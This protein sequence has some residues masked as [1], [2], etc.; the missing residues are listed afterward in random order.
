[1][2]AQET[3]FELEP[4]VADSAS[5]PG[6]PAVDDSPPLTPEQLGAITS[7]DS[8]VF[9]EA[10]AGTGKTRVL[11]ERYCD[12]VE[13]DGVGPEAILAFTFTERAAAELRTRIRRE[14]TARAAVARAR[15]DKQL[16]TQLRRAARETERAWVTTI[17][18][19]CRRLLGGHPVAA[20]IDPRFRVLDEGEA[21]R[22]RR[23]ARDQA[24]DDV[25]RD[26]GPET[27]ETI[28]AYRPW[29]FGEMAIAAHG[30]LRSQGMAAPRLPAAPDPVRSAKEGEEDTPQLTPAESA[31]ALRVD[32]SLQ[33]MGG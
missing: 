11:V 2:S 19:F 21:A 28:A 24:L 5:D 8:D 20:G 23:L 29:R 31:D 26:G 33:L 22:L 3:L 18:G 4:P 30:R 25:L 7:R 32:S 16:E 9:C 15:G 27:V 1:M 14:L 6:R 12:A 17:H 13:D 10:G